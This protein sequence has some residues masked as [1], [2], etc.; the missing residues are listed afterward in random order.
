MIH[1]F[2]ERGHKKNQKQMVSTNSYQP[3]PYRQ[4]ERER[5]GQIDWKNEYTI[6]LIYS[7]NKE[8]EM[9][10]FIWEKW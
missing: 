5:S 7:F 9:Y 8:I 2:E 3:D 1:N 10:N 4:R 6:N